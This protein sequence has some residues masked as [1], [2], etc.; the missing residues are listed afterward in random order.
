M[1]SQ[2]QVYKGVEY[3]YA[4]YSGLGQDVQALAAEVDAVDAQVVQRPRGS[5]LAIVDVRG[6]VGTAE[7]LDILKKSA[8]RTKPYIRKIAVLG[9]GGALRRMFLETVARVSGQTLAAFDDV[10]AAQEW[11]IKP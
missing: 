7:A 6:T 9:V 4:D 5:A 8:S 11:L 3:V 2:W 10:E 1:K